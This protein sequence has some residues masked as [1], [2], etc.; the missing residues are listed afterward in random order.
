MP[1]NNQGGGSGGPWGSPPSGGGN[2]QSPWG[3]GGPGAGDIEDMLRRSQDRLRQA[4]PKGLG[5]RPIIIGVILVLLIAWA[6]T[7][8]YR[9]EPDELGVVQRFG[10]YV[11]TVQ[12]GLRFALPYPIETMDRPS[13]T[14]LN[15]TDVGTTG[16]ADGRSSRDVPTES[17][18]LTGDENIIDIDFTVFWRI[19]DPVAFLFNIRSPGDTVKLAAE[20]AMRE[21]IGRTEIQQALT[22][23]RQQIEQDV[24]VL[25]QQVLDSYG[26]GVYVEQ[27]QLQKVDPPQEVVAAFNDVQSARQDR[28]RLRN[29]AE[30]YRNQIIPEARG[31]AQRLTQE[32]EGYRQ[33]VVSRAIGDAARFT[34]VLA[35]YRAAPDVTVERLYIESLESVLS[36]TQKIIVDEGAAGGQGV[37]PYLPLPELARPRSSGETGIR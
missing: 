36:Q 30:R 2:G 28:D 6:S 18:M 37:V 33:Q 14:S 8:V 10:A 31:N 34:S 22:E 29:E 16:A 13:V 15:R 24:R 32:A 25:L 27:V 4:M 19:S 5:S 9:V 12:P 35:A 21:I 7:G 23:A 26:A 3:R 20:S 17:L 1:W 11:R